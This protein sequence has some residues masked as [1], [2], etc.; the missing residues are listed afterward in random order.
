MDIIGGH[1]DYNLY[2]LCSAAIDRDVILA[3]SKVEGA[4]AGSDQLIINDMEA[5]VKEYKLST[6]PQ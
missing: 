2:S 3:C 1:I 5:E 6:D 4:G